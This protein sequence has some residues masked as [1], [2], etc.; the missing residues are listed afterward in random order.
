LILIG[1]DE[2]IC[3]TLEKCEEEI[4]KEIDAVKA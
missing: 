2:K 1:D 4:G 3:A